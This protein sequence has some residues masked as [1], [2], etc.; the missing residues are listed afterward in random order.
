[1]ITNASNYQKVFKTLYQQM[2]IYEGPL[3]E[4]CP[5]AGECW[6]G[7]SDRYQEGEKSFISAP[8]VGDK[9]PGVGLLFLGTNL[10]DFGGF[11]AIEWCVNDALSK[12]S[13]D[14]TSIYL[15]APIL[16]GIIVE[17]LSKMRM[18]REDTDYK[19][20]PQE[21]MRTVYDYIAF[22]NIIKCSPKGDRSNPTRNMWPNCAS[23]ILSEE[24]RILKPKYIICLS[25]D[26][27]THLINSALQG[28][29]FR[30]RTKDNCFQ[31][32]ENQN[33]GFPRRVV[34]SY[35]PAYQGYLSYMDKIL[36]S[37]KNHPFEF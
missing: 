32:F 18:S 9:Y 31:V 3:H 23:H 25:S 29:E 4:T 30:Q 21:T 14:K 16:G 37:F 17:R 20:I 33:D 5:K 12:D 19:K 26:G 22:T 36:D 34:G 2:G 24:L 27:V 11:G 6:R 15:W 35:H 7:A 13:R 1:M 28:R 10:N 8:W